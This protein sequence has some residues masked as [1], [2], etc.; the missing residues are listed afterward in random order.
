MKPIYYTDGGHGWLRVPLA[1]CEGLDISN[2][3]YRLKTVAYLE[4]DCDAGVWLTAH[5]EVTQP[6]ATVYHDGRSPIRNYPRFSTIWVNVGDA[7]VLTVNNEWMGWEGVVTKVGSTGSL[8]VS[9]KNGAR[10]R[11]AM[12]L[13]KHNRNANALDICPERL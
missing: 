12:D 8:I 13:T 10:V 2:C 7:V 3:S 4:E 1:S 9:G 5:P 11:V 6:F